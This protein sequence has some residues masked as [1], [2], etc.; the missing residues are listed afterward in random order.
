MDLIVLNE[1]LFTIMQSL[2]HKPTLYLSEVQEK[3]FETTGTWVHQ[4]TICHTI[5]QQ[6]F[7][8]KRVQYVALQQSEVKR[9]ECMAEVS[10]FDPN[11]LYGSMKLG[12]TG[13][14]K[15]ASTV[16]Q[17][18]T[19]MYLSITCR[20]EMFVSNSCDDYQWT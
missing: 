3:L 12:L 1:L 6:G 18:Y 20:W 7:T 19:G 4:S 5:K 13:V 11:M 10:A 15:Y 17:G 14:M 16:T 2:I 9:V 8:R